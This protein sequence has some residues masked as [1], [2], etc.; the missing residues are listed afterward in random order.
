MELILIRHGLPMHIE[1]TDGQPADPPLS[2]IGHTQADLMAT[3]LQHE[4]ID[5]LYSSPMKRAWQTAEPLSRAQGLTI[6]PR[7]GVVEFD[8][9][10]EAYIPVEKLK[11]VD[12]QRWL[13]LMKGDV[14]VDFSVFSDTVINTLETIVSSHPGKRVAVTC[15]GGVINV[16]TAHV[17][18]FSARMFFNPDYTSI[19]R[20]QCASSGE[21][22]VI[23]LNE[24][25]HLREVQG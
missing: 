25:V 15:H 11:Q 6:E 21:R 4:S 18:G 24:A 23:T 17:I 13:K 7:E 2:D 22:S 19:N 12:Y 3:W 14:G 9:Q 1:N 16:W 8:R 5:Y 10:A 20:F